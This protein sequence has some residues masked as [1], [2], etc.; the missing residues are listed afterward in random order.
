MSWL[1]PARLTGV[2]AETLKQVRARCRKSTDYV[3]AHRDAGL[4]F[5][6]RATALNN[7]LSRLEQMG[8]L[9]SER[10]G[11][12]RRFRPVAA[13]KTTRSVGK[14]NATRKGGATKPES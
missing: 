5:N 8:F 1:R 2:Y 13:P 9:V 4:W 12:Q 3:L 11:K 7:R 14:E 10:F 6:C